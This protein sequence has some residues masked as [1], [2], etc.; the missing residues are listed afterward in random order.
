MDR[1][2]KKYAI[3]L[4][5]GE[6]RSMLAAIEV[7]IEGAPIYHLVH[8]KLVRSRIEDMLYRI[9]LSMKNEECE[10]ERTKPFWRCQECGYE[11]HTRPMP[12]DRNAF[13]E[14]VAKTE[15]PKCPKCKSVG[16]MPV[17]F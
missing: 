8:L 12:K 3:D 17:G 15:S 11:N 10:Y 2:D 13:Y 1:A 6:M 14:R 9:S 16:F 4:T 5:E 7:A